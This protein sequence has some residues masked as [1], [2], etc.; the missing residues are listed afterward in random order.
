M[1]IKRRLISCALAA[2]TAVS[3]LTGC[4]SK[5]VTDSNVTEI[6]M[7][8]A[9]SHSKAIMT[10]LVDKFNK[11]T[12]KENGVKLN[13]VV[14]DNN[15]TQQMEVALT[16][17]GAPDFLSG[18]IDKL[19]DEGKIIAL[20]DIEGGQ[21]WI[22][23]YKDNLVPN[24]MTY[25]GK[26]Y[27]V[28]NSVTTFGLIY[29]KDMFKAAGIVDENGEAKPPETIAEMRECAKKLT[30]ESKRQYGIILPVKWSAWYSYDLQFSSM[31]S[32]GHLGYNPE[33]GKF[34]FSVLEPMLQFAMDVKKDKSIYPGAEA[35]DNDT[36]RARFAEGNIG[37][38]FGASWDVGVLNDQFPAKCDWG[39]APIPT[40]SKDVKYKQM[41]NY[42]LTWF[43]NKESVEK[44]GA[45]KIMLVYDWYN[46]D[47]VQKELFEGGYSIPN[48][49]ELID[50]AD[51]SKSPKGWKEFANMHKISHFSPTT[52]MS[53]TS[54]SE[55]AATEFTKLVWNGDMSVADFCKRRTKISNDGIEAYKKLHPDYDGS[56]AITPNWF[57]ELKR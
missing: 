35:T 20:E 52:V 51:T 33:E 55:G 28:A 31:A 39:V 3:V 17:G 15:M 43:I 16:N 27:C 32:R 30:N 50:N 44:K 37:M 56:Y 5:K 29:N 9:D 7:W 41:E 47:E 24:V 18:S 53:D 46:G 14:K 34:D 19:A 40:E 54:G 8:S 22:D 36:A 38:K 10:E 26:T 45:D 57:E 21:K 23:K 48:D 11:T 13:Y 42:G 25:N 1:S 49:A 12:G 4:T 2:V 6:T